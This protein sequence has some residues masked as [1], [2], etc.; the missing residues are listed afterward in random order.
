M[1]CLKFTQRNGKNADFNSIHRLLTN[2]KFHVL[3][4]GV[5]MN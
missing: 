3:A 2:K 1:G 5:E 4:A